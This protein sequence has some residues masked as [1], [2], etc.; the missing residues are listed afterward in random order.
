[1]ILDRYELEVSERFTCFKFISEGPK[2]NIT[3]VV[4]FQPTRR[5]DI[6][7][8]AFGDWDDLAGTF[9]D[10]RVSGNEDVVKVLAT[11]AYSVYRFTAEYP[12]A[13]IFAVGSTGTRTRLYRINLGRYLHLIDPDFDLFGV[14][15]ETAEP[16]R[17]NKEYDAFIVTR[18]TTQLKEYENKNEVPEHHGGA[19][20][21]V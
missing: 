6:F 16:F 18:N 4:Q 8:L 15:G 10:V 17:A 20:A 21:E 7:N 13:M 3:K 2:G 14:V 5:E 19:G 12:G 11:V 1:M 9:S